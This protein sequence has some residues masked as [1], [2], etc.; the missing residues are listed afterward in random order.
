M[1][2]LERTVLKKRGH[3]VRYWIGDSYR[4]SLKSEVTFPLKEW[5]RR[6]YREFMRVPAR[7]ASLS[8]KGFDEH[9]RGAMELLDQR[10]LGAR[11]LPYA[12]YLYLVGMV[13]L[14]G[15]EG[16]FISAFLCLSG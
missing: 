11:E 16:G 13:L 10:F 15:F 2:V 7:V 12:Q 3:H 14:F 9:Y 5:R 6:V 8:L 4:G 1:R